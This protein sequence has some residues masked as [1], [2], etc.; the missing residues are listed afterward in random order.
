MVFDYKQNGLFYVI[1]NIPVHYTS[2]L[3]LD[4]IK[5]SRNFHKNKRESNKKKNHLKYV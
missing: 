2:D 5:R 4:T 1:E 3:A